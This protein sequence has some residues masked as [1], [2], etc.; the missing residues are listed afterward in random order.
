MA[1]T[2]VY[3]G[4]DGSI[5]LSVP[6]GVEGEAAQTVISAY[7][8]VTV[9]RVENVTVEVVSEVLAYNEI[10]QRYAT[11]LRPGNVAIRGTIGRAFINGAMLKL[12]L[13]EAADSRPAG[14][15]SQPAFNVTLQVS[16]SAVPDVRSILTLHDVKIE[17]WTVAMPEQAFVM[18]SARFQALFVSVQDEG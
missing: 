8:T 3:T 13:G 2:S 11:Q 16:N 4:S 7:D 17:N 6:S 10:G 1:N 12:C 9:G 5:T 15:W 14:S 18:E